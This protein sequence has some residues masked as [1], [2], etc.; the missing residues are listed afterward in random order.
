M[1]GSRPTGTVTFLFT[2]LEASTRQWEE[3]PDAMAAAV[4]RHEELLR[5]TIEE[6]GG[7]LFGQR[8]D[9][10]AAA[11]PV[12]DDAV[13]AAV[14]GQRA[15]RAEAWPESVSLA[16]RMGVHTGVAEERDGDYFGPTVNRAARICDAAH[17]GQLVVSGAST[18]LLEGPWEFDD[19]GRYHLRGV[20]EPVSLRQVVVDGDR[21]AYPSLRTAGGPRHNLPGF[22]TSFLGREE[23]VDRIV[24]ELGAAR[25]VT[26]TGPGGVGKTRLATEAA[27]SVVDDY[28]RVVFDD[29][30]PLDDADAVPGAV[31]GAAGLPVDEA[32]AGQLD[33]LVRAWR[34]RRVLL[35]LDNCE[36]LLEPAGGLVDRLTSDCPRV[37]VLATSREA[38]ALSGERVHPVSSLPLPVARRLFVERATAARGDLTIDR[39]DEELVEEICRRLDRLP[40]A[41]ELAAARVAHLG[42][43][44]IAAH[45][46]ERFRL[47]TGAGDRGRH[48]ETLRA[49]VNWSYD[50]LDPAEQ[51]LLRA[52]AVFVGGFALEDLAAVVGGDE[53]EVLERLGSLVDKSLVTVRGQPDGTTRYHLLET[54]RLYAR[55]Q[56]VEAGEEDALRQA[57]A[58]HFLRNA[59][60]QPPVVADLG[61]WGAPADDHGD[62][63]DITAA[64]D[65]FQERGELASLGRL[66]SR[67]A[68]L[69]APAAYVDVVGAYFGRDDVHDALEDV[70]ERAFYATA[71]A[72]NASLAGDFPAQLRWGEIAVDTTVDPATRGAAAL[73]LA[74]A[75]TVFGPERIPEI[76]AD[77]LEDLPDGAVNIRRRLRS[78]PGLALIMRD[79][80]EEAIEELVP[81]ARAGD[82]FS[83]TEV[84]LVRHILGHDDPEA[85]LPDADPD[86]PENAGF[87]YR[88]PLVRALTAARGNADDRAATRQAAEGLLEAAR[89]VEAYPV[90]L[91]DR[92]VLVGCAALAFHRGGVRHASELLAV[93][94]G[95]VRSPGSFVVYRHYRDLV[96]ERLD[97]EERR[98]IVERSAALAP[99]EVLNRE[100]TRL[101]S[102]PSTAPASGPDR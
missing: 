40:L 80:F 42:L 100:L 33:K 16:C 59:T 64:L 7:Y 1:N 12:A 49:A 69:L 97:T 67:F 38:L 77:A 25:I 94:G 21:D 75:C 44:E 95:H 99:T 53:L 54:I 41:L 84:M 85:G 2:D 50:L 26:L 19:L 37:D 14:D 6:H 4:A 68:L 39:A 34:E 17:G 27:A 93:T 18:E 90:R 74:N 72:A 78:Q 82:L 52:S 57:H 79:R 43:A 70:A 10:V 32:P 62:L 55:E 98:A 58:R 36:H 63:D 20:P 5:A 24:E 15:M 92:D 61:V 91:L 87:E 30:S 89:S 29:L 51:A 56:L 76:V 46:D 102:G 81:V 71:A 66:A 47:L 60:R 101:A 22:R 73:L 28:D 8:G 65:W 35:V 9:G 88:I 45:L 83:K 13:A 11:F 23:E 3:H 31:A 48:Q 96:R 86:L